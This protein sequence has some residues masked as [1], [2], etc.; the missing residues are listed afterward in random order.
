VFFIY[1]IILAHSF[2][3]CYKNLV[4]FLKNIKIL[5]FYFENPLTLARFCDTIK[6]EK[7]EEGKK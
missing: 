2:L 3:K 1:A 4:D 5:R 7:R 6:I